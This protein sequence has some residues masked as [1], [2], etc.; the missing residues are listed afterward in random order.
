M[1]N[2]AIIIPTRLAAR[3]FPNKPLAEINGIPMIIHVLNKAKESKIG[4]V[5]VATPDDQIANIVKENGGQ[6]IITKKNH[7]SG[8]ERIYEVYQ[9]N[10]INSV[11]LIINLQ[12]DM[13]NIK[14]DSISK[15]EKLMRKNESSVGTLASFIKD[16]NEI[17]DQNIVKVQL[18]EEL[19]KDSFLEAK[20]FFRLKKDLNNEKIYH[21]IGIY[22]FTSDALSKYVSLARSKLEIERNLEQ[23][24]FMENGMII[25]VGFSD[26]LP[27]SVD[28]MEDLKKITEELEKK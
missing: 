13:P 25:N 28:T 4:E 20:D 11:D 10:L 8:T 26:S 24:R 2:T 17:M 21:H 6:A 3:R 27:L 23:M 15:L 7:L 14:P 19:K 5:F 12:G 22:A 1:K 18:K 16:K 9:K